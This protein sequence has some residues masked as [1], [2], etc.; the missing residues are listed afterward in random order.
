M[1]FLFNLLI[2]DLN[3]F[4]ISSALWLSIFRWLLSAALSVL[5][6]Y[7]YSIGYHLA[8]H[9]P[10]RCGDVRLFV[11]PPSPIHI[12][13]FTIYPGVYYLVARVEALTRKDTPV[14]GVRHYPP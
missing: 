13:R 3:T 14:Y 4:W 6:I 9:L 7:Y 5:I 10:V 2:T 8:L 11:A 12:L 1:L